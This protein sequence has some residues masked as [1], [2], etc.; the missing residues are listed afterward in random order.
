MLILDDVSDHSKYLFDSCKI[1][2]LSDIHIYDK[3]ILLILG[4]VWF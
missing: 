3:Y 1:N 4:T 2:A